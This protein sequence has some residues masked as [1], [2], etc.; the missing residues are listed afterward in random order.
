MV[1]KYVDEKA[2]LPHDCPPPPP[3]APYAAGGPPPYLPAPSPRLHIHAATF[4]GVP[5]TAKLAARVNA[6]DATLAVDVARLVDVFAP[7]PAPN[8]VKTL[9]VVYEFLH[10]DCEED[11]G[12]VLLLVGEQS[13]VQRFTISR[14]GGG[15]ESSPPPLDLRQPGFVKMRLA[16]PW[17]SP[18]AG[19]APSYHLLPLNAPRPPP[20]RLLAVTYGHSPVSRPAAL[21]RLADFFDERTPRVPNGLGGFHRRQLTLNNAFFGYDPLPGERKQWSVFFAFGPHGAV[22]CVT[23]WEDGLLEEPWSQWL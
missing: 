18:D 17:V 15:R 10:V 13:R 21:A 6:D 16:Q 2:A 12:P 11:Q 14:G 3:Q 9:V 4:G 8:V 19:A 20:V 7:D 5:V 1:R 22:Q 23:G